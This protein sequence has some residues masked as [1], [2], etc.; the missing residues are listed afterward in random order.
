M[1]DRE[2]NILLKT[3][4]ELLMKGSVHYTDLDKKSVRHMP[5]VRNNKHLQI[6]TPL[7]AKQ[8][9]HHPNRQ[10]RL[11]NNTKRQKIP[12]SLNILARINTYL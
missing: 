11:P 4:L 12:S 8:R 5:L 1:K 7:P 6:A 10:R 9:L 3:I 2:R